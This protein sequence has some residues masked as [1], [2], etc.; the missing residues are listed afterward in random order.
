MRSI[1]ENAF[2]FSEYNGNVFVSLQSRLTHVAVKMKLH[3]PVVQK[4]KDRVVLKSGDS[5]AEISLL[6]LKSVDVDHDTFCVEY[7]RSGLILSAYFG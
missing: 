6:D 5:F 1:L 7:D 2:D 3:N 4:A